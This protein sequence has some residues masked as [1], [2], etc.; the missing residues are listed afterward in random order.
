MARKRVKVYE[1]EKDGATY[2]LTR[3][4]LGVRKGAKTYEEMI[5][6]MKTNYGVW[7]NFVYPE[8]VKLASTLPAKV[9][10]AD[11][12]E[13]YGRRGAPFARKFKELGK[14]FKAA[15]LAEVLR[16]LGVAPAAPVAAPPAP[17]VKE[18]PPLT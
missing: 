3:Y 2:W 14:K 16:S 17:K 1:L 12:A 8:L 13:N 9:E 7:V 4:E 10:G 11:P 6:A 18:I 5:P 15:K